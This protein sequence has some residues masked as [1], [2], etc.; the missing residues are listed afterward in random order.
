MSFGKDTLSCGWRGWGSCPSP[1][2]RDCTSPHSGNGV[3]HRRSSWLSGDLWSSRIVFARD[4]VSEHTPW[5]NK[6][7]HNVCL[8]MYSCE[9]VWQT[10]TCAGAMQ[11]ICPKWCRPIVGPLEAGGAADCGH[12]Q[13]FLQLQCDATTTLLLWSPR[14]Q[15]SSL[16]G[17]I[18][19]TTQSA[20]RGEL[21]V[22]Q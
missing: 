3:K 15:S 19:Q 13:H 8:H 9:H 7:S 1:L 17:Q 14:Q 22:S 6:K 5:M 2:H 21:Q 18:L 4:Y 16:A 12:L 11:C 20:L 10:G